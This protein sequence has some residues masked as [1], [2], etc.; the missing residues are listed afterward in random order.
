M[1]RDLKPSNV[2]LTDKCSVRICDF[3]LARILP[4]DLQRDEKIG[5]ISLDRASPK[6]KIS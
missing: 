3:G 5:D 4:K 6:S 2:L 1:H